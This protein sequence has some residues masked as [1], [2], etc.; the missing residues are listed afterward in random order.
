M[1]LLIM[2]LTFLTNTALARDVNPREEAFAYQLFASGNYAEAAEVFVSPAWQGVAFY[3]S[4]QWWRAANALVKMGDVTSRY[5]LGL[6]YIELG[7]FEL[8]LDSFV[9][10]LKLEPDHKSAKHNADIVRQI[11]N[12]EQQSGE[13]S[14]TPKQRVIEYQEQNSEASDPD[15]PKRQGEDLEEQE[16]TGAAANDEGN[17]PTDADEES[18][19]TG[20]G[21]GIQREALSESGSSRGSPGDGEEGEASQNL[22]R[23]SDHQG[24]ETTDSSQRQSLADT[25]EIQQW[26][27]AIEDN[28]SAYLQ[29][30]INQLIAKRKQL[31]ILNEEGAHW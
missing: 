3:R 19:Q 18:G 30:R 17:E 13:G 8:A 16:D 31:G 14:Q 11:L 2:A 28:P 6:V 4:R 29:H 1:K 20:S 21:D 10:V 9:N 7:Y 24:E 25:Q 23:Q 22:S 5:N 15:Q 27:N 26:L 12:I